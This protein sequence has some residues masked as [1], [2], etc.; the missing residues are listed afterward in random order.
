[1][2]VST[3]DKAAKEEKPKSSEEQLQE[4]WS[5]LST[6]VKGKGKKGGAKGT[7]QKGDWKKGDK[8]G[9]DQGKGAKGAKGKGAKG[10]K[11]GKGS[12]FFDGYC[13][14]VN[15]EHAGLFAG[16]GTET[17]GELRKVVGGL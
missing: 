1:M 16:S 4:I 15:T 17:A 10:A 14:L 3:V 6:F 9:K 2:D 11:G 5:T 12:D 7:W 8:G 13:G